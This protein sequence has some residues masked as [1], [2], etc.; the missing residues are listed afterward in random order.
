VLLKTLA[1]RTVH[2]S[3]PGL[4]RKL[5]RG[6]VPD[7]SF[8]AYERVGRPQGT[9]LQNRSGPGSP[10]LGWFDS[11]A[12]PWGEQGWRF[13]HEPRVPIRLRRARCARGPWRRQWAQGPV[14]VPTR[15]ESCATARIRS[16][17]GSAQ[18]PFL[19]GNSRIAAVN[20]DASHARGRW[21]ETSRAHRGP[22]A[23]APRPP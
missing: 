10:T 2:A 1:R 14:L 23:A 21:F 8:P 9:R 18:R 20:E 22:P 12:A 6:H 7:R 16:A 19:A 5:S 13:D 15:A 17:A 4:S 3:S 11:I